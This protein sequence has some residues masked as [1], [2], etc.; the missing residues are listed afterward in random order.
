MRLNLPLI[1]VLAEARSVL[2]VGMGGGFDIFCGLPIRH[3]LRDAGKTVHLANLSFTS[4]K[5]IKN[6]IFLAPGVFGV[7]ADCRSVLQYV[8]SFILPAICAKP[9]TKPRPSGASAKC[10]SRHNRSCN[11][12]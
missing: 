3:A 7:H 6:T 4:L 1:D 12:T 5:F 9:K 10:H 8:P 11:V 2:I